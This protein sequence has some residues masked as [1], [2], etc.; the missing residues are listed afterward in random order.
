MG[1]PVEL[2]N[3]FVCQSLEKCILVSQTQGTHAVA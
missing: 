1:E 2:L 3:K